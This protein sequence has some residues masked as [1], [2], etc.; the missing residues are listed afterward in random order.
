[1]Y[2]V[3][4]KCIATTIIKKFIMISKYSIAPKKEVR[5][6]SNNKAVNSCMNPRKFQYKPARYKASK[7]KP[8]GESNPR[9]VK[10]SPKTF[11]NP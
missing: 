1:M 10:R 3:P 8:T 6:N 9:I 2:G 7:K 5:G 4:V 11:F